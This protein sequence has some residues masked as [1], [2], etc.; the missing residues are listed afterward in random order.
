MNT[1]SDGINLAKA[2]AE[3]EAINNWFQKEEIDLDQGLAKFRRGMEI[4]KACRERLKQAEN[5]FK[6]IRKE[7]AEGEKEVGEE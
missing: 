2:L 5:E 4:I 1:T 7:F 3:L 6:A